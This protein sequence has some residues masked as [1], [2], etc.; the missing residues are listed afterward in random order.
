[1]DKQVLLDKPTFDEECRAYEADGHPEFRG[2]YYK[3]KLGDITFSNV[4]HLL[5]TGFFFEEGTGDIR[6]LPKF[7]F[8]AS[9]ISPKHEYG[10]SIGQYVDHDD[11]AVKGFCLRLFEQKFREAVVNHISADDLIIWY[12]ILRISDDDFKANFPLFVMRLARR[13]TI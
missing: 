2:E 7:V 1:M 10:C 13:E 6:M 4:L 5:D 11:R 8:D 9:K 3:H 12:E